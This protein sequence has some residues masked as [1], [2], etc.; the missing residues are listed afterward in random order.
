MLGKR[1]RRD[2]YSDEEEEDPILAYA[3]R[4]ARIPR[5]HE[6]ID[7]LLEAAAAREWAAAHA[8]RARAPPRG[9]INWDAYWTN[10]IYGT[11]EYKYNDYF[12]GNSQNNGQVLNIENNW[13]GANQYG[14]NAWNLHPY[15]TPGFDRTDVV[16]NTVELRSLDMT[17]CVRQLFEYDLN[18]T[19]KFLVMRFIIAMD[20]KGITP[21][22]DNID[23]ANGRDDSTCPHSDQIL[24]N[25]KSIYAHYNLDVTKRYTVLYDEVHEIKCGDHLRYD[26]YKTN[27]NG[28]GH[29]S[30]GFVT[31]RNANSNLYQFACEY[32]GDEF[33]DQR[34]LAA[35][36]EYELS[37]VGTMV[38]TGPGFNDITLETT[39]TPLIGT[40]NFSFGKVF[41]QPGKTAGGEVVQD[42]AEM[43]FA[44][45]PIRHYWKRDTSEWVQKIH[46]DFDD[47][48]CKLQDYMVGTNRRMYFEDYGI[49]MAVLTV[50]RTDAQVR[51]FAE[52]RLTYFDN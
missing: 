29:T 7:R 13:G 30:G 42:Q 27:E 43:F 14:Y 18:D 5:H 17:V 23:F 39:N 3:A 9:Y 46:I 4:V 25:S 21:D 28:I 31:D 50:S 32:G 8:R 6:E 33:G 37:T 24:D 34:V 15:L 40:N 36:S 38:G 35:Q 10:K 16:G 48:V 49:Y 22:V 1:R 26:F 44:V 11:T 52:S 41:I 45:N 12:I 47:T 19:D 2:D 51:M 20:T